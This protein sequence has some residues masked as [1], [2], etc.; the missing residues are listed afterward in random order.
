[1]IASRGRWAVGLEQI[2]SIVKWVQGLLQAL[3]DQMP[4]FWQAVNTSRCFHKFCSLCKFIYE[5]LTLLQYPLG[6]FFFFFAS[7]LLSR[8]KALFVAELVLFMQ[9]QR[10]SGAACPPFALARTKDKG[11]LRLLHVVNL[12]YGVRSKEGGLWV[13]IQILPCG[14]IHFSSMTDSDWWY[15][16][17]RCPPHPSFVWE[18]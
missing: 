11:A 5:N 17:C 4:S 7:P 18:C 10:V 3:F 2:V 12:L 14:I 1:M 8:G 16:H 9:S 15:V 6:D 13:N